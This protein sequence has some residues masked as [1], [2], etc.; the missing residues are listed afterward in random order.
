MEKF[1][2]MVT[3]HRPPRETAFMLMANPTTQPL[4]HASESS[5]DKKGTGSRRS[6]CRSR[7]PLR[8]S[9]MATGN[10]K[11]IWTRIHISTPRTTEKV[12]GRLQMLIFWTASH[13]FSYIEFHKSQQTI[14]K[15]CRSLFW[16]CNPTARDRI[17]IRSFRR[18][19]PNRSLK[20]LVNR[21]VRT[22]FC[23]TNRGVPHDH[24]LIWLRISGRKY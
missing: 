6:L 3:S 8:L 23:P 4:G 18:S 13:V 1:L 20:R 12:T 9:V 17:H 22:I 15:R 24:R 16:L 14:Y 5:L 2:A 7:P 10:R 19:E 21:A 11:T